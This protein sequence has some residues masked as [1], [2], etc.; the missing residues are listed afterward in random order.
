MGWQWY[1]LDH[2]QIIC[3][4]LQTGNY[5]STSNTAVQTL[6]L[7]RLSPSVTWSVGIQQHLGYILCTYAYYL[8]IVPRM[9][10]SYSPY[11]T[12]PLTS[13]LFYTVSNITKP[14]GYATTTT[15]LFYGPFSGTTRVSRCQKRTSGLYDAR[16]DQQRQTH[17][18]SGWASRH[19]D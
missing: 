16:E 15:Q 12:T 14:Q 10:N 5:A 6:S 3:T 2:M 18:P 8:A 11:V 4:S 13:F 9:S 7:S 1:Q 19:P 17:R